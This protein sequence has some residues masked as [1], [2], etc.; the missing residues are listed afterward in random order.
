MPTRM[1][2][3]ERGGP[4]R[5]RIQWGR[6]FEDLE[7]ALD[8]A[9]ASRI[10]PNALDDGA[11]IAL[12]D[13]SS[14]LLRRVRRPWSSM[15]FR[16]ELRVERDAVPLPGSDGDPR[17]IGRRAAALIALFGLLQF[18]FLA[19]WIL[20]QRP[21]GLD[22]SSLGSLAPLLVHLLLAALAALGVRLAVL[23]AAGVFALELAAYLA[24][25]GWRPGIGT[26]ILAFVSVRLVHAWRLMRPTAPKVSLA[27]VFE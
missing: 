19:M 18:G 2:A 20:F 23:L 14:L 22:S 3:L 24:A 1:F 8:G 5:L 12:A 15:A 16:D 6:R 27:K 7:V 11:S 25:A 21:S 9:P 17:A 4:K 26:L 13:G 10:D